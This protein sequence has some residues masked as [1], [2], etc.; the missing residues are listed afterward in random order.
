MAQSSEYDNPELFAALKRKPLVAW[1]TVMLIFLSIA[2]IASSWYFVLQ[3]QMPLWLGFIINTI[4]YYLLFSPIHDGSHH[5]ISSND[6]INTFFNAVA[7]IP[8]TLFAQNIGFPRLGHM[9]HHIHTGKKDL[10]PDLKISSRG[11]NAMGAWFF[12]GSQYVPYF[13][14]YGK[15]LPAVKPGKFERIRGLISL[16]I[17]AVVIFNFPLEAL[18][19][20]FIPVSI[21]MAWMTEFVFSYLPHHIHKRMEGID[22]LNLYQSTCNITG[23]EWLLSPLMQYQNYHL[24][25]HLYP[26]VPFYRMEKIWKANYTEHMKNN[27]ATIDLREK[28][29][30]RN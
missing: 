22:P 9:Q 10:D 5:A 25:H 12:W 1:P 4:A 15:E 11:R 27:P 29:G 6:K 16:L 18:F 21:G 13:K 2:M 28:L 17:F 26:T 3:N 24:V 14:K 7:Y 8:M 23:F 30:F 19:L 20:W